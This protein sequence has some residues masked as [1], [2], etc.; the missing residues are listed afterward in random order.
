MKRGDNGRVARGTGTTKQT[1]ATWDAFDRLPPRVRHLM[2]ETPL[3]FAPESV[4]ALLDDM[5]EAAVAAGIRQSAL[6]EMVRFSAGHAREHGHQTPHVAA[7]ASVQPYAVTSG[8]V[9][10]R[11]GRRQR[12]RIPARTWFPGLPPEVARGFPTNTDN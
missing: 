2:W 4:T 1:A 7:R 11:A 9:P 12:R 3:P 6:D 8:Q 10:G 5:G